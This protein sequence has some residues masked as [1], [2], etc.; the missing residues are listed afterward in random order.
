MPVPEYPIESQDQEDP[1]S[2]AGERRGAPRAGA[3]PARD[4]IYA[5]LRRVATRAGSIYTSVGIVLV[6]GA[7]LFLRL[8]A[9]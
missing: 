3:S 2:G 9:L 8:V 5:S 7:F 6:A 4:V 1:L